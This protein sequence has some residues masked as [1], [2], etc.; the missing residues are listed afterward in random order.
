MKVSYCFRTFEG[1]EIYARIASFISTAHKNNRNVYSELST[2]FKG[3]IIAFNYRLQKNYW[4]S[5]R[6]KSFEIQTYK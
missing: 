4:E 1:A 5:F 3:R 6:E 2:T